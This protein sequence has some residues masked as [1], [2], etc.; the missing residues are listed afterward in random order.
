MQ[1]SLKLSPFSLFTAAT[2]A[3]SGERTRIR[4]GAALAAAALVTSVTAGQPA[5]AAA[6]SPAAPTTAGQSGFDPRLALLPIDGKSPIDTAI[7]NARA[8]ADRTAR[9]KARA[10]RM[11]AQP[12]L[13]KATP[14]AY[15][16]KEAAGTLGQNDT[17]ATAERLA[18]FG[19]ARGANPKAVVTGDL[20]P[21]DISVLPQADEDNGAIPL[22]VDTGLTGTRSVVQYPGVIGDGPH[23]STGDGHGDFDYYKLTATAGTPLS[24]DVAATGNLN[25][26][27]I[28]WTADGAL[29]NYYDGDTNDVHV[30]TQVGATGT[31][32]VMVGGFGTYP[33]DPMDPAS[34]FAPGTEGAY[35]L[36]LSAGATGD[37]DWYSA[38]LKAGDILGATVAGSSRLLSFSDA[39]GTALQ[40][41]SSD[42]SGSYAANSPL[43]G[44]GNATIDFVAPKAGR[45]Y[46]AVRSGIGPY[47]IK[48]EAYRPGTETTAR[49]T[50]QTIF[51]DFDGAR[52]N[53]SIFQQL[54]SQRDLSPL[55]AF[56]PAWG[57][58][59]ADEDKIIDATVASVRE[60]MSRD[61]AARG[62]N[63]NFA[64]RI[65]NS[66][67]NPDPFGQPNVSRVIVGGTSTEA[68][69]DAIGIAQSIDPGN[70]G[71]EETALLMLDFVSLP[72]PNPNS[73][74]TFVAPGADKPAF[75]GRSLGNYAAHEA[76]HFSGSWH[77]QATNDVANL[78]DQG[79]HPT[80]MVGVG[81][82]GLGGTADDVDVDYTSDVYDAQFT[83][84]EDAL[85]RT[86]WA[87]SRGQS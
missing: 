36:R 24:I 67:D 85:N 33:L 32:Y 28:V 79:G 3:G 61:L 27:V 80:Q 42:S 6:P 53:T 20:A 22:A 84:T 2:E 50:V 72:A 48:V 69:I 82:D 41:S 37:Q 21:G 52:V 12:A 55:S 86:A 19:T 25:T 43:P 58:T 60:N 65:L 9:G 14:K 68:D 83:G 57:L 11:N 38:D 8:D 49:G 74:N 39:A 59:A 70:F 77:T 78:M 35:T 4:L 76:G 81:P 16:E 23:S 56:L 31:W 64:I 10:A 47:S 46:L 29:Y 30:T 44:G 71:H 34:G 1:R 54:G 63:P 75:I 45:Y 40:S 62:T 5:H 7:R 73:F 26:V 87:Y 18:G 66:R 17:A 15:A 51:L 13:A